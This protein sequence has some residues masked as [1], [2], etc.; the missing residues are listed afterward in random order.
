[1]LCV[2]SLLTLYSGSI[3][4]GNIYFQKQVIF[5]VLGI[6]LMIFF[7]MIDYRIFRNYTTTI[8]AVYLISLILLVLVLFFGRH[9]RGSVSWFSLGQIKFE[10]VEMAKLALIILFAKYFSA[11]HIFINQLRHITASAVYFLIPALLVLFQP[12]LGSTLILGAIWLGM[13]V[14]SGMRLRYLLAVLGI[15]I[16]I[17]GASWL[18]ILKNY[19]KQR[20]ISFLSPMSDPLGAGYNQ[21]QA[22]IAIGSGGFFGK[23]LG[24]GSQTQLGFLPEKETD[25][26]F[27]ALSEEWGWFGGGV[28]LL[29]YG[30]IAWRIFKTAMQGDTNFA[31]LFCGGILIMFFSA[32]LINVGMNV[33]LMP[34]TGISLPFLSYGGSG[35]LFNFIALGIVQSIKIR[36]NKLAEYDFAV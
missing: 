15:G 17:F 12:D 7:S 36:T 23:G 21:N 30:I 4:A 25:F 35:L 31:K 1:M 19:Q 14:L 18:V 22:L 16:L 6:L 32:I 11:K 34:I 28:V 9:T 13:V 26:I 24:R 33:G 2:F 29:L 8:I 20:I 3:K 5:V 27:A 10:P